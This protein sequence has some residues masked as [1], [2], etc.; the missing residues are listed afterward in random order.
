MA[1]LGEEKIF[2]I[3][4]V[5][6]CAD[7]LQLLLER[8]PLTANSQVIFLGDYIDRGSNSRGVIDIL[9]N[10]KNYYKM[11]ALLGNHEAMFL[12]FL[13]DSTSADA[14]AF[15]YNGGGATLSSYANRQGKYIIPDE[16]LEFF[17]NLPLFTQT[18][19]IFFVHAGV[20]DVSL[21]RLV[22]VLHRQ[23]LLWI[24]DEF[25]K[26]KFQWQ[27]LI[28]HG[29]TPVDRVD[30][31][32][33][34]INVDTGCVYENLL[35]AIELPG[36][37]VHS[38]KKIKKTQPSFLHDEASQRIAV[39]FEGVVPVELK[40]NANVCLLETINYSEFGML[41]RSKP[42]ATPPIINEGDK[43]TGVVKILSDEPVSFQGTVIRIIKKD[44]VLQYAVQ[45]S[46]FTQAQ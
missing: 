1:S 15:I 4:D 8:L 2:A 5:H 32:P 33:Q 35:S 31:L 28:V 38:V 30:I 21:D 18:K 17:N 6:G 11:T 43:V 13:K 41:L 7:E 44:G 20:P 9:L 19:D 46:R 45:L 42:G 14:G 16:H 39:R 36:R 12:D 24:R 40:M 23:I 25:F 10:F 29:H 37:I 26:S 22:P 27:K 3:G 34:R